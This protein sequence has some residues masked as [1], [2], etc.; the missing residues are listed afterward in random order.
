MAVYFWPALRLDGSVLLDGSEGLNW[1]RQD[2]PAAIKYRVGQFVTQNDVIIH[3]LRIPLKA[4]LSESYTAKVK[5]EGEV[6]FW[7]ALKLD[8]SAKL[9]GSELLDKSR[10]PWPVAAAVAA[11]SPRMDEEMENVTV[12]TRKD[13]AYMDGSLRLDGTRILDSE[14]N[15]EAI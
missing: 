2:W 14:Y 15:K 10:Q 1:S 5:H 13:L 8:G 6:H 9:D 4:E 7:T 3:R 12:I 11:S